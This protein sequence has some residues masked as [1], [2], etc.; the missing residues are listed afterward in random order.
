M[1]VKR[2]MS[3]LELHLT[4]KTFMVGEEYTIADMAIF[5]WVNQLRIGYKNPGSQ[6]KAAEFLSVEETYPNVMLWCDRIAA[7]PAVQRGL[8]VCQWSSENTKPWLVG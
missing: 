4:G 5:P 2:L 7:R 6:M 8:T 1:E 3:V